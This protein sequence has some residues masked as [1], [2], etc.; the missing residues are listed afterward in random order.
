MLLTRAPVA[1]CGVQAHR[2]AAPRLACVK[3]AASVHPEPGSNSPLL[4]YLS[5]LLFSVS[6]RLPCVSVCSRLDG[7]LVMYDMY[8]LVSLSRCAIFRGYMASRS[9][10][11]WHHFIVLIRRPVRVPSP[12][13]VGPSLR[14]RLQNY[15]RNDPVCKPPRLFVP[16]SLNLFPQPTYYQLN[17]NML[18]ILSEC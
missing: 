2:T 8:L 5:I 12:P 18:N 9:S 15:P 17:K 1:G 7:K 13:R 3:P 16:F 14:Q 11:L 10:V 6:V 4:L